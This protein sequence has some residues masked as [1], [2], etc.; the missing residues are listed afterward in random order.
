MLCSTVIVRLNCGSSVINPFVYSSASIVLTDL[1]LNEGQCLVPGKQGVLAV[2]NHDNL[3]QKAPVCF[4]SFN[5][6]RGN[7]LCRGEN[8]NV[9]LETLSVYGRPLETLN[10]ETLMNLTLPLRGFSVTI[11]Y[12]R[13]YNYKIIKIT[14]ISITMIKNY[15]NK[16]SDKINYS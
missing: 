7:F 10:F 8:K 3:R 2:I 16:N 6:L 1:P 9:Q 13:N 14:M 4:V 12:N 15:N 5:G 11:N